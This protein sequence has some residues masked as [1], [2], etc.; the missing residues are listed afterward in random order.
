MGGA[1]LE[2][3]VLRALNP[4][5]FSNEKMPAKRLKIEASGKVAKKTTISFELEASIARKLMTLLGAA[6]ID[7]AVKTAI[8]FTIKR[9]MAATDR[10]PGGKGATTLTLDS[11]GAE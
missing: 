6:T 9:G 4:S 3:D 7:E 11:V 2:P 5:A 1:A 8:A 10:P